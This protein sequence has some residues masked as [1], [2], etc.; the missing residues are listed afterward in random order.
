MCQ[1]N[2]PEPDDASN[3]T[4]ELHR[5]FGDRWQISR[6]RFDV[7]T[8]AKKRGH[9]RSH[10]IVEF[11]ASDLMAKLERAENELDTHARESAPPPG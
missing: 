11:S 4:G 7:W 6:S 3:D 10:V 8:A 2:T 5:R 1:E 9:E